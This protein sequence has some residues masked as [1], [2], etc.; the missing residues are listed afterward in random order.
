MAEAL[1]AGALVGLGS[2]LILRGL[3]PG[4]RS[5]V[6]ALSSLERPASFAGTAADDGRRADRRLR[7]GAALAELHQGLGFGQSSLRQDLR[8]VGRP[9]ERHMAEKATVALLGLLLPQALSFAA[10]SAYGW[11]MAGLLPLWASLAMA[12]GGFF[13]PDLAV[14]SQAEERRASFRYALGSFLDLVIISLA[15]GGGVE[16][17]LHDS[18][19]VGTGW[20]YGQLQ[21]ALSVS[22]LTRETPWAALA[23]LGEELGVPE[24]AELAASVGL[25]GTEGARVRASLVAKASSLRTHELT[26]AEAAAESASEKMN[27]PI[28]VLFLGFLLFLGY[29]AVERILTGI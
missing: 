24:L 25:A 29:P 20:A 12:V 3:L 22:R 7:F 1:G 21:R 13:V 10:R 26:A 16:S 23:R 15:G 17:A 19:Q 4:R 18:A 14:R 11:E 9:M 6:V 28:A 2:L 5:L 8:V 27:L